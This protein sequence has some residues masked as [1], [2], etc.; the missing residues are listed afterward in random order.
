[1][2]MDPLQFLADLDAG[3]FTNK[4]AEAI[5]QSA[6][7]TRLNRKQSQVK[8]TLDFVPIGEGATVNV[9]HNLAFTQPTKR[10]KVTEEDLT[11]T[12]MYINADGSVTIYPATQTKLFDRE[13][14]QEEPHE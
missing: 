9:K 10:G 13:P 7:G 8:I 2:T 3:N 5:K 12:Q 11:Q 4:L 14:N 6:T 1:M